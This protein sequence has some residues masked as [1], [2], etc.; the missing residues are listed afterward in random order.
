MCIPKTTS[1]VLY[2]IDQGIR[3][4][5]FSNCTKTL[6][7]YQLR[8]R[9][10]LA[11][12][13]PQLQSCLQSQQDCICANISVQYLSLSINFSLTMT[14]TI[15]VS[16][17]N[18]AIKAS[19]DASA[20]TG[21]E[22]VGL[23][24]KSGTPRPTLPSKDS[25]L[26]PESRSHKKKV[27]TSGTIPTSVGVNQSRSGLK[28]QRRRRTQPNI[29]STPPSPK[30]VVGSRSGSIWSSSGNPSPDSSDHDSG[31]RK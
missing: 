25:S 5:H 2:C 29:G 19:N 20:R 22:P 23:A 10:E 7:L 17:S 24:G 14:S 28:R 31:Y 4:L 27:D 3:S 21:Y 11:Y 15:S 30:G 18:P 26:S 8:S 6:S 12:C 9:H 16:G 13:C 1:F